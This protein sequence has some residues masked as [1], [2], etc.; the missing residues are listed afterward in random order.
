MPD[1][2]TIENTIGKRVPKLRGVVSLVATVVTDFKDSTGIAVA[3]EIWPDAIYPM[4]FKV[5]RPC[6]RQDVLG[7]VDKIEDSVKFIRVRKLSVQGYLQETKLDVAI[8]QSRER[9][10]T[11]AKLELPRVPW[12]E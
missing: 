10:P 2:P 4:T 7:V 8:A 5:P 11:G 12:S 6:S 9:I 3:V 1:A